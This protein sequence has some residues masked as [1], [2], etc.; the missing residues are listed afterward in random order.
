[1]AHDARARVLLSILAGAALLPFAASVACGGG[2]K[3][4]QVPPPAASSSGPLASASASESA[5]PAPSAAPSE[6]ASAAPV[7]PPPVPTSAVASVKADASWAACHQSFNAGA[8]DVSKD[9]AAM[10]KACEKATKMK[11]VGKTLTGKQA[12]QEKPQSF[13]FDAKAK[14]CYRVYAQASS[15]IKDLDV[16]V[17]DSA[18]VVAAQDSTD[19]P[20]PVVTEDGALCFTKDDK[21]SVVVS[22]GMGSGTYALQIWGD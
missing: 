2:E 11:P 6:T 4:P 14:H 5:A 19:D 21:A 3:P 1:M 16:V 10:G 22:V 17:K 12:D 18:G 20:S 15:G 13:P 9:A 8:K 7:A